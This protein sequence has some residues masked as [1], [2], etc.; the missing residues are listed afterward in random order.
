MKW[1]PHAFQLRGIETLVKQC[2]AGQLLDPGMGKTATVLA[3]FETLR[4]VGYAKRMLVVAPIKPMYTT[5]RQEGQKWDDFNHFSFNILHGKNKEMH[6]AAEA[7]IDLINP[8]GIQWLLSHDPEELPEWDVLCIDESTKFKASNSKRFKL[9]KKHLHSFYY[10]WILTGTVT[11]NGIMDLFSQVY[12][13]DIGK[14][15]GKYITKF[16]NEFFN[17]AGYGGYTYVPI[18]GAYEEITQRIAHMV[19]KLNAEDYLKMPEFNRI[20]RPVTLPP[21]VMEKYKQVEQQF[22][23]ELKGKHIV[24]ANAA[25]AGTKCRQI[26]NGRVY[27]DLGEVH[28]VHDEKRAALEEIVEETNG[29][30]LLILYEFRHDLDSIM[31]LLGKEAVCIT[32]ITGAKLEALVEDFNTGQLKYMVAHGGST[33]GL[34]IQGYCYHMVWY[35]ITWNLEHYI[36]TVWRLYRQGQNAKMVL[37][38]MLVA[39]GTLDE[40]VVKV[41]DHK[42]ADMEKLENLLME[43]NPYV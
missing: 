7:D 22:I 2:G 15:L 8:E 43:Y 33:H 38:Y 5:W 42:Q 1:E 25:A 13:L 6:L 21:M 32:G 23:T 29:Q 36:Q 18:K 3:A 4:G 17:Q 34:N 26:A 39:T 16:R 9:L 10:R 20:I 30:P 19:L 35:G 11:P 40:Q 37:C 14:S 24:A 28:Y 31:D 41:L 27:D 12:I